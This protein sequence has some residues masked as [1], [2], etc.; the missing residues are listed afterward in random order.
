MRVSGIANLTSGR[1]CLVGLLGGSRDIDSLLCYAESPPRV[2]A[3]CATKVTTGRLAIASFCPP[4][5]DSRTDNALA[6]Q[7]AECLTPAVRDPLCFLTRRAMRPRQR[8][9]RALQLP[10][11]PA[12]P[13]PRVVSGSRIVL[14]T[15]KWQRLLWY[16]RGGA[17][18]QRLL[19]CCP[20]AL[21]G[22]RAEAKR[23]KHGGRSIERGN[24]A[25]D[26]A[27]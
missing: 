22:E 10:V 17:V 4:K 18:T 13:R 21:A 25:G 16:P 23:A 1:T 26:T 11:L 5:A 3:K 9:R 27:R 14:Q 2:G 20:S 15:R 24:S 6:D 19:S 7:R 8:R 12:P